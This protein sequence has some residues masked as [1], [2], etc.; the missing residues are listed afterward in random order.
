MFK[1]K[2]REPVF[3]LCIFIMMLP[4]QITMVQIYNLI[5]GINLIDAYSGVIIPQVFL[6]I[7]VIFLRQYY[8]RIPSSVIETAMIDGASAITIFSRVAVPIAKNGVILLSFLAFIDS[9][10]MYEL[11]LTVLTS[12]DKYPLSLMMRN[13]MEKY[14][15]QAFIPALLYMIPPV[16]VY[17]AFRKNIIKGVSSE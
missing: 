12:A 13:V 10:N 3:L 2:F 8:L 9:Y 5:R 16:L 15:E 14:P 17:I 1:F 11:P 4:F 6:P 7:G